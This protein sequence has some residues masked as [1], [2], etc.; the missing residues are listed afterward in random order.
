MSIRKSLKKVLK[1]FLKI[2]LIIAAAIALYFLT[3][4][5]CSNIPTSPKTEFCS[6]KNIVFLSSN[7]VHVDIIFPIES[8]DEKF[9]EGL[10]SIKDAR[11]VAFGWGDRG[12][13]LETPSWDD[14]KYSTVLNA[15]LL[16]SPAV[17]HVSFYQSKSSAWTALESCSSG[18]A[19]M[20]KH[21]EETF[22]KDKNGSPDRIT[23]FD[24]GKNDRFFEAKGT[25]NCFYTC[26]VWTGCVLKK[27]KLKTAVWSPF[28][29]GIMYFAEQE[30]LKMLKK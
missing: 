5:I 21:I 22:K 23:G 24:Y 20:L 29:G 18:T 26:N 15:L 11:Y 14:L 10:Q 19:T 9:L 17:M 4:L 6:D 1:V 28:T 16:S 12:F 27:G 8:I 30:N 25:Y 7:G 2:L 13:Y 3:A